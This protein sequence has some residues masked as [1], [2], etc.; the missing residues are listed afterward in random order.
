MKIRKNRPKRQK[1]RAT[2]RRRPNK[3]ECRNQRAIASKWD[4]TSL[5]FPKRISTARK[6]QLLFFSREHGQTTKVP[7]SREHLKFHVSFWILQLYHVAEYLYLAAILLSDRNLCTNVVECLDLYYGCG[8][9]NK[10]IQTRCIVMAFECRKEMTIWI[11]HVSSFPSVWFEIEHS[12][13]STQ[14]FARISFSPRARTK[15]AVPRSIRSRHSH[16]TWQQL[17]NHRSSFYWNRRVESIRGDGH[18][19]FH[20]RKLS[21]YH[22]VSPY[23]KIPFEL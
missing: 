17:E 18:L 21:V 4:A 8:G 20:F 7:H 15:C 2:R 12:L 9:P 13:L 16:Q 5:Q 23:S 1:H 11:I 14:L 19:L 3:A 6:R 22:Y 10:N